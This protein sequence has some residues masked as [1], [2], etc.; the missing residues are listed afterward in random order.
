MSEGMEGGVGS[1]RVLAIGAEGVVLSGGLDGVD[2][3]VGFYGSL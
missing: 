3:F 1:G 2:E